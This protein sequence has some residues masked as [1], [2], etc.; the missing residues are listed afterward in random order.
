MMYFNDSIF[1]HKLII[2]WFNSCLPKYQMA[3]PLVVFKPQCHSKYN[4]RPIL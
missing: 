3:Y 2:R 1:G 4:I